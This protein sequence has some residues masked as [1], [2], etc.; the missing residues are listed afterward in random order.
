MTTRRKPSPSQAT[1]KRSPTKQ[2]PHR[3]AKRPID[4]DVAFVLLTHAPSTI[5]V[6][7]PTSSAYFHESPSHVEY[8]YRFDL[9]NA[10][11]NIARRRERLK[12]MVSHPSEFQDVEVVHDFSHSGPKVMRPKG[13]PP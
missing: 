11:W 3:V 8:L 4:C 5:S 13:A 6:F 7:C 10:Q 12:D 2:R 9:G 1:P